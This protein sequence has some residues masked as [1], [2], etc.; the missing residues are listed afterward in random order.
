MLIDSLSSLCGIPR[1]QLAIAKLPQAGGGA[2]PLTPQ[3]LGSLSWDE[4]GWEEAHKLS[5]PPLLLSDGD[6]LVVRDR[7]H[8]VPVPTNAPLEQQ[9]ER[10]RTAT[11]GGAFPAGGRSSLQ[12]REPPP[13]RPSMDSMQGA[14]AEEPVRPRGVRFG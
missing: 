7:H 2:S 1:R 6:V 8:P 5:A 10:R 4:S 14:E 12:I 11:F 9:R 13:P 3:Q